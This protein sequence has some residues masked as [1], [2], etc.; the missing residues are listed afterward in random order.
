MELVR[1]IAAIRRRWKLLLAGAVVALA[2]VVALGKPPTSSSAV[3]WT[4][5]TLDTPK[6]QV[7]ESD[8]RGADSLPWRAALLVHL[9]RTDE[10]VREIARTVGVRPED[11]A[12]VDPA[13]AEP[14]V[15]ASMPAGAAEAAS[16]SVAPYVLT[17]YVRVTE[18][19]MITIETAAPD[20][21]GAKRLAEAAVELLESR[22]SP[23]ET[24]YRSRIPTGGGAALRYQTYLIEAVAPVRT[25]EVLSG[26]A[27][28][29][30]IG[31][32]MLFGAWCAAVLVLPPLLRSRIRRPVAA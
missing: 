27:P 11:V 14:Q 23:S 2:L 4:R 32:L 17:V 10:S 15:P 22:S 28:T 9:M 19:P 24:P 31:V 7:V 29:K 3:G 16:F 1:P 12:V 26:A 20:R 18:L 21:D 13:L 30:Q 25:K 5:V 6:S 8:P